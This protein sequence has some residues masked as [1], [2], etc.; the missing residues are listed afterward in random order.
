[1][2]TD[3]LSLFKDPATI[4]TLSETARFNAGLITTVVGMGITFVVLIVLMFVISLFE[5]FSGPDEPK[6]TSKGKPAPQAKTAPKAKPVVEKAEEQSA[7]R[8]DDGLVGAIAASIAMML[9]T[10]ASNFQIRDIRRV[11]DTLPVWHRAGIADQM[12]T[13]I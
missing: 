10:P 12:Q 1:M 7:L 2:E 11:A 13:R 3:L 9:G 8:T 6:P 4:E 5:K